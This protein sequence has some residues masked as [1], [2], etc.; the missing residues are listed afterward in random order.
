MFQKLLAASLAGAITLPLSLLTGGQAEAHAQPKT[1]DI[2]AEVFSVYDQL[3]TGKHALPEINELLEKYGIQLPSAPQG[4]PEK[5]DKPEAPGKPAPEKPAQPD[6]PDQPETPGGSDKPASEKPTQPNTPSES[7]KPAQPADNNNAPSESASDSQ[8][9]AFEKKVVDLTNQERE[10]AGLK[11][12]KANNGTLSK[13]ARDKSQ[14]MRDN[15]YFDH[16]S[17]TYGSPFDMMKKYGISFTTAGENIAAGQKSPEEVVNGWMNS[18]GH[19]KNILNPN[20]TTIGVGYVEGGSYGSYW[21][22]EFIGE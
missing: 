1:D 7:D 4:V 10:K 2:R 8:L 5:P 18:E 16:Q 9:N 6:A 3:K 11:S 20:F 21:T 12:L 19:R 22:Q 17:P 14:D 13:M 15:N